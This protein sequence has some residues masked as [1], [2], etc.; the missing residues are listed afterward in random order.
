MDGQSRSKKVPK[1]N[2]GEENDYAHRNR[3]YQICLSG[4]L[5]VTVD[6]WIEIGGILGLDNLVAVWCADHYFLVYY[7]FREEIE[8]DSIVEHE[9]KEGH[10]LC[11]LSIIGG[12]HEVLS[13]WDWNIPLV[14]NFLSQQRWHILQ[15]DVNL[16]YEIILHDRK[17]FKQFVLVAW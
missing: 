15:I 3:N 10:L 6:D 14:L 4:R 17:Q 2:Q 1:R 8:I 12:N 16:F 11:W 7:S 13:D 5:D 9:G